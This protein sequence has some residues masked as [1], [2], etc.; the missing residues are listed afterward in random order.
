[1]ILCEAPFPAPSD[2]LSVGWILLTLAA[3]AGAMVGLERWVRR[4]AGRPDNE[5]TLGGQPIEV[6]PAANYITR[7]ELDRTRLSIIERV[8]RLESDVTNITAELARFRGELHATETRIN[9]AGEERASKIH[10]R[11][12]DVL[13]AVAELRGHVDAHER[14]SR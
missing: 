11:I 4:M 13:E 3:L 12:N 2:P 5:R 9:A 10:E 8:G 6:R 14:K 7:D 1:M